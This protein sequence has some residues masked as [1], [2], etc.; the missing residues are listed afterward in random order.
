MTPTLIR[1]LDSYVLKRIVLRLN[2]MQKMHLSVQESLECVC[3]C[4]CAR[5]LYSANVVLSVIN[6]CLTVM[7]HF[8]QLSL[9]HWWNCVGEQLAKLWADIASTTSGHFPCPRLSKTTCSISEGVGHVHARAHGPELH[10]LW[11]QSTN[12]FQAF[13][14]WKAPFTRV[15]RA[16]CIIICTRFNSRPSSPAT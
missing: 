12:I 14:K 8:L 6:S 1:L 2:S 5:L 4:V 11:P 3:A 10:H 15:K 9:C 16:V 7:F 13:F